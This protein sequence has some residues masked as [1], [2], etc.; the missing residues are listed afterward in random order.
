MAE[1]TCRACSVQG[2]AE[3]E[4]TKENRKKKKKTPSHNCCCN[5]ARKIALYS[6]RNHLRLTFY[7]LASLA[8]KLATKALNEIGFPIFD[9]QCFEISSVLKGVNA[10][11]FLPGHGKH[12]TH[13]THPIYNKNKTHYPSLSIIWRTFSFVLTWTEQETYCSFGVCL[14]FPW[15][16]FHP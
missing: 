11:C 2:R 5:P 10:I 9:L 1:Q 4:K 6:S 13:R 3:A 14:N 8:K 16:Q 15:G 12:N 7:L